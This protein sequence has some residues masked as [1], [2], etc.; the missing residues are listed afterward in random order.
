SFFAIRQLRA[1]R[2]G[3]GVRHIQRLSSQITTIKQGIF[4]QKPAQQAQYGPILL[5]IP[6]HI[7]SLANRL[8]F[9]RKIAE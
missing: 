6:L 5:H 7:S 4:C 9:A 1:G 2:G 3:S 8:T